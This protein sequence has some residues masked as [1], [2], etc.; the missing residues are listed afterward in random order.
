MKIYTKEDVKDDEE[1]E[2]T[3]KIF[4]AYLGKGNNY[5]VVKN[6]L[7]YRNWWSVVSKFNKKDTNFIWTQW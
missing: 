2:Q 3:P 6:T 4:K 1:K 5:K 7:K